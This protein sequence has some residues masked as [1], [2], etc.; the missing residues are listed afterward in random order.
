MVAVRWRTF[1]EVGSAAP[2]G[3]YDRPVKTTLERELKLDV[4][5]GFVLPHL[6]GRALK[7]R[8][9]TSTY[10]DTPDRRLMR[11]GITLRRRVENRAGTWQLKLP[12]KDGRYELEEKGGPARVTAAVLP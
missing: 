3:D 7:P 2:G 4:E 8:T 5:P 12:S 9:F 11:S 10:H 6:G 1:G